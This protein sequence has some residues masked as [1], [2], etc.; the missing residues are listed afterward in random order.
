MTHLSLVDFPA[1]PLGE[2]QTVAAYFR[3]FSSL[4][5]AELMSWPPDVFCL[6]NLVLD[7]TEGYRFVVAPPPSRS[8]P[9][10]ADWNERVLVAAREWRESCRKTGG[11]PPILVGQH[12]EMI[13]RSRNV[14][15]AAIRSG[16]AWEVCEA[17]LTL[18]AVADEACAGLAAA[19]IP[20]ADSFEARASTMLARH[21][22]LS[23]LSPTRVRIVPKTNSAA[24]GITI[25]SISRYLALFYESVDVR[26]RRVELPT[27]P[28]PRRGYNVV[29]LPWPLRVR[30]TDFRPVPSPLPQM[31]LEAFGFFEFAPPESVEPSD[32]SALLRAACAESG[33]V[34]AVILPEGALQPHEV[35]VLEAVLEEHNVTFLIAGVRQHRNGSAFGRNYL[36]FGVRTTRGWERY[37]QDKHHRWC[38]DEGQIRQYHLTHS[39]DPRK[40]WWEAI[41]IPARILHVIDVGGG[42]TT[43]PLVCEDLARTDEVIDLLR[44]I[45][46]SIVVAVLLDGPQLA[47][48]WPGRHAS[49]LADEPGS[50]VLTLTSFGMTARSRP[51]G[52]PPSRVVASWADDA[53]R[54]HEIELGRGAQAILISASVDAKKVWTADGRCHIDIPSLT[55]SGTHDLRLS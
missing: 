10:A 41:D 29:L 9:P 21:G 42:A 11:E 51:P 28:V 25:R 3:A 39:L 30:A 20:V 19:A 23:R 53:H 22:S 52:F 1:P 31:D 18:H 45:G 44:R 26:W 48:R 8:W 47:T 24:R 40:R 37:Q 38:L 12:W 54:I 55:L 27:S 13:T 16:D 36:H 4:R 50:A 32:V 2:Q 7:H 33:T 14:S 46:P 6:C 5:W 35:D 17:L 49:V 15:L 43:A 34:D